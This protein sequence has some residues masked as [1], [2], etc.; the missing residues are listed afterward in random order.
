[1]KNVFKFNNTIKL[2]LLSI[3]VITMISCNCSKNKQLGLRHPKNF[4]GI[5]VEVVDITRNSLA[6]VMGLQQG[7][8]IY[9]LNNS[10]VYNT[11]GLKELMKSVHGG[12]T[13]KV[14]FVRDEEK[15]SRTVI[16][17]GK[18]KH[19][20]CSCSGNHKEK[21]KDEKKLKLIK[22]IKEEDK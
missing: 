17:S 14:S 12:M 13:L 11:T 2:G 18:P 4:D 5:G 1:M 21:P 8:I 7:D 20:K 3:F 15:T 10:R 6:H 16:V 9:K 22:I 19:K